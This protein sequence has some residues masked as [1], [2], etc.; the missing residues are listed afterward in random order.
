[1]LARKGDRRALKKP[2]LVLAAELAKRNHRP[3]EGDRTNRRAQEQLEPVACR[4]RQTF[5]RDVE[6][7]RLRHGGD[8]DEH[9]RQTN[10]AVHEG[11]QLGHLGHFNAFGHQRARCTADDQR[12]DN[13]NHAER[14]AIRGFNNQRTGGED[15]NR[16]AD[17]AE[18]ISAQRGGGV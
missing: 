8:G 11:D 17:H 15:R 7:I 13:V 4:N 12:A 10:H 2:E 14:F 6:R 9:S 16:H 5:G 3:A 1:M 18:Q